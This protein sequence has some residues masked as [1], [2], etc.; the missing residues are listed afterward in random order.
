MHDFMAFDSNMSQADDWPAVAAFKSGAVMGFLLAGNGLLVLYLTIL[1]Y[2][3]VRPDTCS[4]TGWTSLQI[5]RLI[6][7]NGLVGLVDGSLTV[8]GQWNVL[9]VR[10]KQPYP[11]GFGY[12]LLAVVCTSSAQCSSICKGARRILRAFGKGMVDCLG[13][14]GVLMHR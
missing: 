1:V 9:L 12:A 13:M 3:R 7:C 11:A 2:R 5:A 6:D 4:T 10:C 8:F 14:P